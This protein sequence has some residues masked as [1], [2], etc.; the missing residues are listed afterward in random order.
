MNIKHILLSFSLL[1][2]IAFVSCEKNST[3]KPKGEIIKVEYHIYCESESAF[4]HYLYPQNGKMTMID[5]EQNKSFHI[6]SFETTAGQYFSIEA[7]NKRAGRKEISVQ[8]FI[9]G[10]LLDEATSYEP[11]IKAI[12]SGNF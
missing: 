9:N 6:I 11:T 10:V 4:V 8:V 5:S 12:A 2:S 3:Y 1:V 7:A